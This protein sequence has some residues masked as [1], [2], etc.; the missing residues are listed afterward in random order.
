MIDLY[1]ETNL[2]SAINPFH[3][4]LSGTSAAP[5]FAGRLFFLRLSRIDGFKNIPDNPILIELVSASSFIR[6]NH[7]FI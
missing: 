4:G 6:I 3:E 2:V 5:T 1:H 7:F